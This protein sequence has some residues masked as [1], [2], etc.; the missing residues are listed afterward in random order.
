MLAALSQ[1]RRVLIRSCRYDARASAVA[2]QWPGPRERNVPSDADAS[3]LGSGDKA[4]G[5]LAV[6]RIEAFSIL[7]LPSSSYPLSC[8]TRPLYNYL[9]PRCVK[10]RIRCCRFSNVAHEAKFAICFELEKPHLG[11]ST[12]WSARLLSDIARVMG[13]T[14]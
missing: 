1:A 12:K 9:L 2:R 4:T 11:P 7:V 6:H 3:S 10:Y 8:R 13:G 5:Q 14:P